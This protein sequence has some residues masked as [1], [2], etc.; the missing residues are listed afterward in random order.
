MNDMD[1]LMPG[2]RPLTTD[3]DAVSLQKTVAPASLNSID[4]S[5]VVV[6]R[7]KAPIS[8][9]LDDNKLMRRVSYLRATNNEENDDYIDDEEDNNGR[10]L[11][12]DHPP[13]PSLSTGEMISATTL[14]PASSTSIST[15]ALA[16][17]QNNIQSV[18]NNNNNMARLNDFNASTVTLPASTITT[19]EMSAIS[20]VIS[21][22]AAEAG[23]GADGLAVSVTVAPNKVILGTDEE[24]LEPIYDV[25]GGCSS[26]SGD[27]LDQQESIDAL[28]NLKLDVPYNETTRRTNL[29]A[30]NNIANDFRHRLV[31]RGLIQATFIIV[32]IYLNNLLQYS[33]GYFD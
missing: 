16:I 15:S 13:P 4:G 31:D 1:T 24:Q 14:I 30:N 22:T 7:L 32:I 2:K 21:A 3:I 10:V 9:S 33:C 20:R 26:S 28:Q 8:S 6:R 17:L 11:I 27:P 25:V 29:N 19:E 12:N 5:Q 23:A 18:N